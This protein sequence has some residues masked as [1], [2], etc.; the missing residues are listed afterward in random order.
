MCA[1]TREVRPERDLIRF[2]AG[3]EGRVVPDLKAR[4]PGRGVWVGLDRRLVAEAARRKAFSRALKSEVAADADLADQVARLMRQAALG[5]LGL[6]RRAGGAVA[7]FAKTESAVR[8]GR[9]AALLTASDAARDGRDKMRAML[10]RQA[11]AAPHIELFDA[12]ELG[13][14]LGRSHVIHAAVLQGPAGRSFKDAAMRLLRY[15]GMAERRRDDGADEPRGA[16]TG[17]AGQTTDE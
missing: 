14:A 11:A 17:M 3:P 2:V 16:G 4:L 1:V 13:L 12:A 10:A 15:E 8:S 6:A 9:L 5:R 7:G